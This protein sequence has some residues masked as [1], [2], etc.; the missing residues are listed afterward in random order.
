MLTWN[1]LVAP[2]TLP[3]TKVKT[4]TGKLPDGN[5]GEKANHNAVV[6]SALVSENIMGYY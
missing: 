1:R 6:R 4:Y 5:H 2:Q 3:E